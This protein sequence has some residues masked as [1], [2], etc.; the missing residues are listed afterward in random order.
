MK[1]KT[2]QANPAH[3]KLRFAAL[4]LIKEQAGDMPGEEVLAVMSQIVGGCLALLD[5]RRFS[6][7]MGMAI[8]TSNIETGNAAA[9]RTLMNEEGGHA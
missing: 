4:K 1:M 5:Q 6:V 3:E 7:T 2:V 9:L 8:I